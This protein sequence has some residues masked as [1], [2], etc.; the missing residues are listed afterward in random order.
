MV[1]LRAYRS[2]S[3]GLGSFVIFIS[4]L[5]AA[6]PWWMT[7]TLELV[8][9][10]T[11]HLGWF[12]ACERMLPVPRAAPQRHAVA[13]TSLTVPPPVVAA[14]Q[15]VRRPRE[16]VQAPVLS[17]VDETPG[18][19][20]FRI[21]RPQG[22]DFKA[23]QFVAVKV[24]ADGREHVRCYSVS[25][26]PAAQGY[27]EISVKRLGLVSGALHATLRPGS[28]LTFK[29][30]AGAFV[31]PG[32]EDRPIVLIAGGV[33]I[34]PL[35]SMLRYGVD[36]EPS[37][38]VTLFYSVRTEQ[39]IAFLDDI[40]L[41]ERR[42]PQFRPFV[43]I[44]DGL[45]EHTFFPGRLNETLVRASVRDITDAVCL[46]CGPREM[47][48]AMKHMLMTLGVAPQQIRF[49]VFN[50]AVAASAGAPPREKVPAPGRGPAPHARF[51]RSGRTTKVANGQTLLEAAEGC[52]AAIP[53]LCRAGVCGTCRTRVL[54]GDVECASQLLDDQDRRGGY[55]LACVTRINSDCTVEA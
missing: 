32:G 49:E 29:A 36:T 38:P 43:A 2:P 10:L 26:S 46:V 52:G 51:Q 35:L 22:C 17:V 25:S 14:A 54:S 34:T 28:M 5:F 18:I 21:A 24:R 4:L 13:T 31:Y 6:S 37:R 30:P 40:K 11:A 20:T 41:L 12:V 47:N 48:E 19:R 33:G 15:V 55:V 27:L 8:I 42:H 7:S 39:D 44:T 23:G 1:V 53:S 9:G 50:A 45:T 16:F 3:G